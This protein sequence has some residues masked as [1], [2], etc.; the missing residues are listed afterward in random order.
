[1]NGINYAQC[2]EDAKVLREGLQVSP[3]DDVLSIGSGG[4]NSLALLLDDPR[5]VTVLDSNPAQIYV[6]EL[7]VAG[8]RVFDYDDFIRFVGAEQSSQRLELYKVVRPHLS[9]EAGQY[10]DAHRKWIRRGII[11]CGKFERYLGVFRRLILPLVVSSRAIDRYLASRTLHQ[12]RAIYRRV[13][14]NRRWRWLFS[15]FFSRVVLGRAGRCPGA[16]SQVA[17]RAVSA[18]LFDRTEWG[19]TRLPARENYLLRYIL[20]GAHDLSAA[21][22]AYLSPANFGLIRQRLSRLRL[23]TGDLAGHLRDTRRGAYSAF[24][25]SDV[26]EYLN[27]GEIE[28]A[29]RLM[30]ESSRT[31]TRVV[32]WTMFLERAVPPALLGEV[33]ADTE[34]SF[35]LRQTDNGF[36]YGSVNLWRLH[37]QS[38]KAPQVAG[39]SCPESEGV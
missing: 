27:E 35:R 7:K 4:D 38:S 25:L 20:T 29:L 32:F 8:M 12:Q 3:E 37:A 5:S 36:F 31:D 17:T 6:L 24:N 30:L 23:V 1:M 13:W 11:H 34:A 21:A 15:V 39:A 10:W 33:S 19:L 14:N 2:W 26:F 9:P 18:E 16:F 28:A 22:P